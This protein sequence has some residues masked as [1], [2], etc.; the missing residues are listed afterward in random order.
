[1]TEQ[2][3]DNRDADAVI[4][5]L[6]AQLAE[7][8]D[9][10]RAIRS[11]EVDALVVAGPQGNQVYTLTGADSTYRVLVEAMNEGALVMTGDGAIMYS[12]SAFADMVD[13][14]LEQVIGSRI[15]RF[16]TDS[17]LPAIDE[18]LQDAKHE[19]VKAEIVLRKPSNE[20]IVPTQVSVGRLPE[21]A[22][23][24][25]AVVTDL[26][27]TKRTEAELQTYR[28]HL[29]ELVETRTEQ[30]QESVEEQE[31]LN[32]E[33]LMQNE[34][35][36][37]AQAALKKALNTAE[38]GRAL[39]QALMENVPTGITIL[40][41][42]DGK[43]RMMS[44]Y[45]RAMVGDG[46]IGMAVSEMSERWELYGPHDVTPV[47][48][49][50]LPPM[51]AIKRGET[52][53]DVETI[54]VDSRGRLRT[55]LSNAAPIRDSAGSIIGAIT[56]WQDITERKLAEEAL[57][58][59]E[60]RFRAVFESTQD[61]IV[62]A[63]DEGKYVDAN[64]AVEA[65]FGLPPEELIGCSINDFMEGSY[66]LTEAWDDLLRQG[67]KK[68]QLRIV[69]KDGSKRVVEGEAVANIM[70]GRHL[71]VMHDITE[72]VEA[73]EAL[74]AT[75]D[76]LQRQVYLL[77]RALIP[78]H[79]PTV[80]GYSIA[81]TYVPAVAG[82]EIGGDF[83]DVFRTEDGKLGVLI[84]D[85]SGK[86]IESAAMAATTRS[87]VRAFAYHSSDAC[88]SMTQAN[89]LLANL[90]ME[91]AQFVTSVLAILDPVTGELSY[92]SAGHPPVIIGHSSGN[93]E[94]LHSHGMPL[95]VQAG[96]EYQEG[97][98]ALGPGDSLVL[99]TDGVSEA[100][101]DHTMFGVEGVQSVL[102]G[103]TTSGPEELVNSIFEAAMNYA[104]GKLRDD[105]AILII[106]R[107]A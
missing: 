38:E 56:V 62:I 88:Y 89:S 80:E 2:T 93:N 5:E 64:P 98:H 99:Y 67:R 13:I 86:G 28:E 34:E 71:S 95:G 60:T 106:Q 48:L 74:A 26:T 61:A 31:T 20:R 73:E 37:R 68:D 15:R 103:H 72:R 87:T 21:E 32:E 18:L 1:M 22:D 49:D 79:P 78:E 11:G 7:A 81:S 47:P 3:H 39:L 100:R 92:S 85:V 30:L 6:R 70:P 102:Q 42:P 35:L 94:L 44:R 59:S 27:E 29:E 77:Q 4:E 25:S 66:D 8:E 83:L 54:H 90:Q 75:K 45:G 10:L 52:V 19:N 16:V 76:Q 50:D 104:E 33:L 105:T 9:T 101:R 55:I 97:R 12:N 63:D 43:V 14:P 41:A 69:R 65:V 23:G 53:R 46:R 57:K 51:R 58:E 82:T 24:L 17:D 84:G 36:K 40:D 107:D 96:A 91:F